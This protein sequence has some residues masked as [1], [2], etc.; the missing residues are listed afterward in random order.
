MRCPCAG[1]ARARSLL[2]TAEHLFVQTFWQTMNREWTG[3]DRLRLDKYCMVRPR[4]RPG[5]RGSAARGG[6]PAE[7]RGGG[8]PTARARVREDL[9]LVSSSRGGCVRASFG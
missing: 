5:R 1:K 9:R 4:P 6:Q 3:I 8:R 7:G 2:F